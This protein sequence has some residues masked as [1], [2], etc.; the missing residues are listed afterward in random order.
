M[1]CSVVE[2]LASVISFSGG[3]H[4]VWFRRHSR[5]MVDTGHKQ[6]YVHVLTAPPVNCVYFIEYLRCSVPPSP[7]GKEL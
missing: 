4:T 5:K 6:P 1:E 2:F 7:M 3:W